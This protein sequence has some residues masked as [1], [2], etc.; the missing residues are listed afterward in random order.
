MKIIDLSHPLDTNSKAYPS[1][2]EIMIR[3]TK[4]IE[5]NGSDLHQLSLG[6][7]SG[8]H[9]DVPSHII[10]NGK[11]LSSFDLSSFIGKAIKVN[12]DNFLKLYD[13]AEDF[14]IIIFDTNWYR[15]FTEPEKFYGPNRPEIPSK[16]IEITID[17]KIKI[18][19]TDLP[20]ID[21]SGSLNKTNHFSLLSKNIIIYESLNNLDLIPNFTLIRFFG[22]PL[23]IKDLDGSPTRA[24]GIV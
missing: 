4:T 18:F 8:T 16:L 5:K 7:H 10:K 3:K 13:Y 17:L 14:D 22:L 23:S 20:S 15:Y 12:K 9:L 1:D 24:I 6:T 11:N 19:C 21:P 2:P